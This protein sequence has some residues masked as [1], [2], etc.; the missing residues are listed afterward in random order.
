MDTQEV[1]ENMEGCNLGSEWEP[2]DRDFR[3][4][5]VFCDDKDQNVVMGAEHCL[6][7]E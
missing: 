3:E 1:S 5:V 4:E 6:E 2:E 7:Y